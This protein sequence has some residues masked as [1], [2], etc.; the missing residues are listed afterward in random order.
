MILIILILNFCIT[1][2]FN[3]VLQKANTRVDPHYLTVRQPAHQGNAEVVKRLVSIS[4][5]SYA[6]FVTFILNLIFCR[7]NIRR[8]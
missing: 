1:N 3:S 2:L 5:Y 6:I 4:F 8:S 7:T